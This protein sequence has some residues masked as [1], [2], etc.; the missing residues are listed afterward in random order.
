MLNPYGDDKKLF[1]VEDQNFGIASGGETSLDVPLYALAISAKRYALFNLDHENRPVIRKAL[2][3]GL[4]HWL[5]PYRASESPAS[6]PT[7]GFDLKANHLERWHYDLWYRIVSAVVEEHP[8]QID[9]SDIPGLNRPVRSRYSASTSTLLHWFDRFNKD[10]PLP[11]Q[12]RAF[13]FLLAYQVSK[14][15]FHGAIARGDITAET[16]DD[17]MPAVVGPFCS[18][19]SRSVR[20]CFDRRT[21][22][23]VPS[24]ILATYREAIAGYHLHPES[25]FENGQYTD[26]GLTK[27]RHVQAVA[28]EHIGKE[29]NRWEEKFFLGELTEAQI[30]YGMSAPERRR[31]VNLVTKAAKEFDQ[32]ALAETAG[33]SRQHFVEILAG[34]ATPKN[35]TLRALLDAVKALMEKHQHERNQS[36]IALDRLRDELGYLGLTQAAQKLGQD[37]SNLHEV[38]RG[39]RR[40]SLAL[41]NQLMSGN[42]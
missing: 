30:E 25:K 17:G 41:T 33:I 38:I 10:K 34:N 28:V 32:T 37:P 19:P 39:I 1:K 5:S 15:K 16:V 14:P 11:E 35:A 36:T 31:V 21:G 26:V 22:K 7:P 40:V 2:A 9:L 29:A 13:N 27:R 3:H 24:S 20:D 6:I 18:D 8:D 12:V 42:F 23:P 4:G